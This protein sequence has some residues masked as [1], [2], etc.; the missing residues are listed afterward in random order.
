MRPKSRAVPLDKLLDQFFKEH[1]HEQQYREL[2]VFEVW[3]QVM[4]EEI[5]SNA[6]PV[7]I[8]Q[9]HLKVAV[10][11]SVWL[12]E[13]GFARLKIKTKLNRK[14]GR[15][16]IKDI[17]FRIGPAPEPPEMKAG[18]DKKPSPLNPALGEKVDR[19]LG[20]V[21]DKDL[22]ALLKDWFAAMMVK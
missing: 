11:N 21:P 16:V 18:G 14:L 20:S 22:R 17:S 5:K 1:G 15:G 8:M 3:D 4:G 7:S 6:S 12:T 13:L 9:G 2:K 10:R 19:M